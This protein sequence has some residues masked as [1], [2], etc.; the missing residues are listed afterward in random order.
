[1]NQI[2]KKTF[3]KQ[4][5]KQEIKADT[6]LTLKSFLPERIDQESFF[7]HLKFG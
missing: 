6:K 1:M 4:L 5:Q 3:K 2:K 7:I